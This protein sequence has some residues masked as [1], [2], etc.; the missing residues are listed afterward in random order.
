MFTRTCPAFLH[1]KRYELFDFH[2]N[3][4][5]PDK[6]GKGPLPLTHGQLERKTILAM[7]PHG[8]IPIQGFLWP[9]M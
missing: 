1:I 2:H 3:L 7:H 4:A 9:A 6:S 5:L 8:V